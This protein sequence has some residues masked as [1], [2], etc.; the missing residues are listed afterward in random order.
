MNGNHDIENTLY[1]V[2]LEDTILVWCA[3]SKARFI[4]QPYIGR[5]RGEPLSTKLYIQRCLVN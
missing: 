5:I 2:K 3:I 1:N 4:S